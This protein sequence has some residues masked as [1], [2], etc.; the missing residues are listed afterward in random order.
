MANAACDCWRRRSSSAWHFALNHLAFFK[1]AVYSFIHS[2]ILFIR[3]LSNWCVL[4]VMTS[5][6]AFVMGFPGRRRRRWWRWRSWRCSLLHRRTTRHRGAVA[7]CH[8]NYLLIFG[9][10]QSRA[11]PFLAARCWINWLDVPADREKKGGGGVGGKGV[12]E[13]RHLNLSGWWG[14][15]PWPPRKM[16]Q[17]TIGG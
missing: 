10:D 11:P 1:A 14:K 8:G 6:P 3:S 9:A 12:V 2:F 5:S 4:C 13:V 15:F 17:G 16:R 7:C